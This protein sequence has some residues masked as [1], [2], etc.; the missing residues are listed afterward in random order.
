MPN[1]TALENLS[2]LRFAI[3]SLKTS[4]V[5]NGSFNW[6]LHL[7]QF[8]MIL[9]CF[10]FNSLFILKKILYILNKF[11]QLLKESAFSINLPDKQVVWSLVFFGAI[12]HREDKRSVVFSSFFCF[13]Q[14]KI[15]FLQEWSSDLQHLQRESVYLIFWHYTC[16]WRKGGSGNKLSCVVKRGEKSKISTCSCTSHQTYR[17]Y[18]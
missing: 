15:K 13:P 14:A 17:P 1:V 6:G 4:P 12:E 5:S 2:E 11:L 9:W 7:V 10:F 3:F 8:W 16:F 18:T